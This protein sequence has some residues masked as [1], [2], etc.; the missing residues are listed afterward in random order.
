MHVADVMTSEVATVRP[1]TSIAEARR[2]L[3]AH[4]VRHLP[5]VLGGRVLGMVSS[6]DVL[7]SDRRLAD[8]LEQLGSDLAEGRE[9]PVSDVMS[10][11][12][13]SVGPTW[14]V[15]AAA[16]VLTDKRVGAVPVVEDGRLVGILSVVDCLR[17]GPEATRS[18]GDDWERQ[19]PFPA[20]PDY[21]DVRPGRRSEEEPS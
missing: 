14:T 11:P 21:G 8:A 19:Q 1:T 6:R 15:A 13:H 17:A 16:R 4:S 20:M 7:V 9:R 10:A 12:V 5:V 2:L 18:Y 3:L